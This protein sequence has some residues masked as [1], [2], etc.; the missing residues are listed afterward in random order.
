MNEATLK[1]VEKSI[2]DLNHWSQPFFY[3]EQELSR[4]CVLEGCIKESDW[5]DIVKTIQKSMAVHG[6]KLRSDGYNANKKWKPTTKR[7]NYIAPKVFGN[8]YYA[9][10]CSSKFK[11]WTSAA[12]ETTRQRRTCRHT[13]CQ[14]VLRL[15]FSEEKKNG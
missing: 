10:I 1:L 11:T 14:S 12:V 3:G 5:E 13:E 4:G 8:K 15:I 6:V 7:P 9:L 2:D